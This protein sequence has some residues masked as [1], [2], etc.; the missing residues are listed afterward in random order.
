MDVHDEIPVNFLRIIDEMYMEFMHLIRFFCLFRVCLHLH[1]M[2]LFTLW[3][4]CPEIRHFSQR[5][6]KKK[7]TCCIMTLL[8]CVS[9]ARELAKPFLM[10]SVLGS[11]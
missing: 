4:C 11:K 9:W 10:L 2:Y 1:W 8:V 3:P 6:K 7:N 5:K